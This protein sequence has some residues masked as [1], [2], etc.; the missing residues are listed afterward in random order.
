MKA[1]RT[2][3]LRESSPREP[4]DERGAPRKYAT[5]TEQ[6]LAS[7]TQFDRVDDA[8]VDF[9]PMAKK[10]RPKVSPPR[11]AREGRRALNVGRRVVAGLGPTERRLSSR[12]NAYELWAPL[13]LL[14][15]ED[16][17][18]KRLA[19]IHGV[20]VDKYAHRRINA[21]LTQAETFYLSAHDMPPE[22]RPLV[23]YYFVLNLTKAF[24][25]CKDPRL[26][27]GRLVHGLS[28]GFREKQRYW[29]S[30]EQTKVGDVTGAAKSASASA[31]RLRA[32][33]S[34]RPVEPCDT[35]LRVGHAVEHVTDPLDLFDRGRE[36][37]V[38][39]RADALVR[40]LRREDRLVGS[41]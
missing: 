38:R 24:L 9:R 4:G 2:S 32:E 12:T 8:V 41:R 20:A 16:V 29:F 10:T 18:R 5:P 36:H 21:Y 31:R 3:A 15:T 40:S 19:A 30:Q 25:T 13:R 26:T 7:V 22:S 34:A 14:K 39:H 11:H 33:T 23:A 1:L 6:G 27:S 28:D 37:N 17:G 35:D